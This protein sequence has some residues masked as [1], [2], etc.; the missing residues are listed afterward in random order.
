MIERRGSTLQSRQTRPLLATSTLTS[1]SISESI[2]YDPTLSSN[3]GSKLVGDVLVACGVTFGVA[4]FMS[5]IDKAIVQRAAGTHTVLQSSSQS[6]TSIL[7]NPVSFVK[8]PMFLM[9]WSVY[10]ATYTTGKLETLVCIVECS[11]TA[12]K[13][14]VSLSFGLSIHICT[15]KANCLK[16]VTE[17]HKHFSND[18]TKNE[19]VAMSGESKFA[20]FAATT[21]VNSS[22]SM[23]KDKFYASHFGSSSAVVNIPRATYGLWAL[24]D[25]TVIGS[26][27]ILPEIC[28]KILE[29]NSELEKAT[30][31]RVSQL[32]V[33]IA[34]QTVA[35]PLQLLGLDLYNRPLAN[36]PFKEMVVDRMRFQMSNFTSIV[37]ARVSRIAPAYGLGGIGNTYFRDRWR[38]SLLR[39]GI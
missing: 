16:T 15:I 3:L 21:I 36:T 6:I 7:R 13:P 19:E 9:M 32:M 29:E 31:L 1:V 35:S 18:S 25:C 10:A 39:K 20:V 28:G 24:R 8:S 14:R 17:H 11:V 12:S 4:P 2:S 38:E 26:S 30:A 23:M 27:F 5:V 33:P 22:T 37:G 34:A